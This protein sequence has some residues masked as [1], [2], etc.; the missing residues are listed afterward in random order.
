MK[1]LNWTTTGI[2]GA[3]VI[4]SLLIMT[5]KKLKQL[6]AGQKKFDFLT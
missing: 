6:Y 4:T 1:D 5:E 3:M 2:S